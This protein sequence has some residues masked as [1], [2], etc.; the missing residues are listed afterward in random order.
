MYLS[1]K[2]NKRFK[3]IIL[4]YKYWEK[5]EKLVKIN[6]V[7]NRV[8]F[9]H[10]FKDLG[11]FCCCCIIKML[12]NYNFKIRKENIIFLAWENIGFKEKIKKEYFLIF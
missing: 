5:I 9:N 3:F 11:F 8:V 2:L 4:N 1:L 6:F 12:K 7:I 10:I